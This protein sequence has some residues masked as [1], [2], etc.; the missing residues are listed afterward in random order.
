MKKRLRK[1]L[2][3]D[4]A[5]NIE[6]FQKEIFSTI[7]KRRHGTIRR[8]TKKEHPEWFGRQELTI[9]YRQLDKLLDD[10]R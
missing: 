9:S 8:L 6:L 7:P 4:V 3:S 10:H 2:Y 1:K 5:F